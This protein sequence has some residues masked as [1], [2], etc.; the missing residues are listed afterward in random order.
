MGVPKFYRWISERYPCLSEVVR[1]F[2]IPDFDNLYLDMNGIIH[3]CSHPND[4]DPHFRIT[5]DT[6][7]ANI[8]YYIDFLFKMIK[9]K[10]VFFMAIDGVAPRA[11]MNQQRGRRFRTAKAAVILEEQ[12]VALGEDLPKEARFD[13]N[14]ITPGTP[15]MER[16]HTTL[17]GFVVHKMS[18]DKL[19]HGVRVYLS[20]H[21]T[22]GEGE[23]K[24]MDF[25]R[26][27]KSQ[28]GYNPNTRHCLYGLDADLIML[29]ICSHEPHFSLLREEVKFGG[30]KKQKRIATPEETTF[31]LLHISL[32]RDYL[33]HEF[34]PAKSKISFSFDLEK[35][36]DDFVL[37]S[38]LV[39]N[40]FIPHLPQLH[41]HH[42]ALPMLFKTY[43]EVLP[44]LGGYV[45]EE[46]HLNLERFQKFLAKLAE[47]DF[48]K[49]EEMNEDFTY[50]EGKSKA[51]KDA[52]AT[53][54]N[55]TV[56]VLASLGF[57]NLSI[58]KTAEYDSSSGE[59]DTSD[60]ENTLE[61][62]FTMHK[63]DYYMTK[64]ELEASP[65]VLKDQAEG[66][67][68]AI[69]WNLH[70]Y[71]NGVCSWSWYYPH[72]YSP[73][74]SDLKD[75][76]DMEM[77]FELGKPFLPFQQLLAVLPK[78]SKELLPEPYQKLMCE[79]DSPL[80]DS[81]P[82]DFITDLNGKQQEWEAVVLIPFINEKL[83]IKCSEMVNKS[84]TDEEKKRNSH[85]PHL[86]YT[87]CEKPS[88]PIPSFLPGHYP[89][90]SFVHAKLTEIDQDFFR[91]DPDSIYKGL[92][93]GVVMDKFIIGFPTLR[94]L[95]HSAE[96]KHGKV[97][98]FQMTSM[99]DNM[100]LTIEETVDENLD[101]VRDKIL[102]KS[103]Y[104]GWPH[105]R[106]A[107]VV[108]VSD[109]ET[110]F[111]YQ[112]K[113]R[114]SQ[115]FNE[116]K[117]S[118]RD[119]D[120]WFRQMEAAAEHSYV[121][122]GIVTGRI[123]I[124]VHARCFSGSKFVLTKEGKVSEE[125]QY[126]EIATNYALQTIVT[127]VEA[128]SPDVKVDK[129]AEEV[130]KA[131]STVFVLGPQHY[132]V[133]GKIIDCDLI[134]NKGNLMISLEITSEPDLLP[135]I[136]NQDEL[137]LEQYMP[138]YVAA[139]H[140]GVDSHFLSRITGTFLVQTSPKGSSSPNRINIG[141]NLK[142]NRKNEEVQGFSKKVDNQWLYSEESVKTLN[143]Y[144]SKFAEFF[145]K[146]YGFIASDVVY[147]EDI[148]PDGSGQ[149][150]MKDISNWIKEQPCSSADRQ[151]CGIQKLDNGIVGAIERTVKEASEDDVYHIKKAI[152]PSQLY[153]P[154]LC[155][156]VFL[157]DP[158][159]TYQ[160]F[161]RVVNVCPSSSVPLGLKGTVIGIQT[162]EKESDTMYE[163][164]F[165]KEFSGGMALIPNS[166]KGYRM[167]PNSLINL[168]HGERQKRAS[169]T[170]AIRKVVPRLNKA[171]VFEKTLKHLQS[172]DSPPV[173]VLQKKPSQSMSIQGR[174]FYK[175]DNAN[176]FQT[177]PQEA[178]SPQWSNN[179]EFVTP[180]AS[181]MSGG[182][183]NS[184]NGLMQKSDYQNFWADLKKTPESPARLAKHQTS[185]VPKVETDNQKQ[186]A[187]NVSQSKTTSDQG[188]GQK[189]S[190]EELFKGGNK[191]SV[192]DLFK[193]AQSHVE[194][195]H[196]KN[197]QM[198]QH[199]QAPIPQSSNS[200]APRL[201]SPNMI[202][203]QI[204]H[205]VTQRPP[206]ANV[207]NPQPQINNVIPLRT[208]VSNMTAPHPLVPNVAAP[209]PQVPNIPNI[210]S[211]R[212]E[213][214]DLLRQ[215]CLEHLK[216]PPFFTYN[217]YGMTNLFTSTIT[218]PN[219]EKIFS[220]PCNTKL[221]AASNAS[222]KALA[223]LNSSINMSQ[224][225]GNKNVG[226]SMVAHDLNMMTR[227]QAP[228]FQPEFRPLV[229]CPPP[230]MPPPNFPNLPPPQFRPFFNPQH[231]DAPVVR[232]LHPHSTA[233]PDSYVKSNQMLLLD[234]DQSY[235]PKPS[236]PQPQVTN[237]VPPTEKEVFH[238]PRGGTATIRESSLT[239]QKGS[240]LFVPSQVMKQALKNPLD[241]PLS[242]FEW[243]D[244]PTPPKET[245]VE[246]A[247]AENSKSPK[248][249]TKPYA[250]ISKPS[251]QSPSNGKV[252]KTHPAGMTVLKPKAKRRIAANFQ[253]P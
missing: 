42:D 79:N 69:Q 237:A 73:Y 175:I 128:F 15:F 206:V 108:G 236:M 193:G 83:L 211:Q 18:A 26:Y 78:L 89:D 12:A 250:E 198:L 62:E 186:Q 244:L 210:L 91:L 104:I 107:L 112:P 221:E 178:E 226:N 201:S 123:N 64:L 50:L 173:Q 25:I 43:I 117:I 228:N 88:G 4:D 130:F 13:S 209:R 118:S 101:Q 10:K 144:L 103:V 1:E 151:S 119:R 245:K 114:N 75:F 230:F 196:L 207:V 71:Y 158:R 98:V 223:F 113:D 171:A 11:K 166:K 31:H 17:K 72:H 105:L 217:N 135:V 132:G 24:I 208:Q 222:E 49:F 122:W 90:L 35:I 157:P 95:K 41:I 45:N 156:G 180:K 239:I 29:G 16:L 145:D 212:M 86:L 203:S 56:D 53:E 32:L 138:G 253:N 76:K 241:G 77:N 44:S 110:K 84:L 183:N 143:S 169:P 127:K 136:Q 139:Q 39:G 125:K 199:R 146:L 65:E 191:V 163:I 129:A 161:D 179:K 219:G 22:P 216:T 165:D 7:F 213:A 82:D 218:L 181:R 204:S 141:L 37:M 227:P 133:M 38:F 46:G 246:K 5:E 68:R 243:P 40:D 106:E 252:P 121:R 176:L 99:K 251:T 189:L 249:R 97:K 102:G 159:T 167:P 214:P 194:A 87:Y 34:S 229:Y 215:F 164:L 9:P 94:T 153:S 23:H 238:L 116:E 248:D 185:N 126:E 92:C 48:Q 63:A 111:T 195:N 174:P 235:P 240:D 27:E 162:S 184:P 60:E 134:S 6:I 172:N 115:S 190:V 2:Q 188:Y 192:E 55:S 52:E 96:L 231:Y 168:S 234:S 8:C 33:Y 225:G 14:C 149:Q 74:I 47:Y 220:I 187:L 154:Y 160:L 20:G 66:Y 205:I 233:I 93:K 61:L 177:R 155:K 137:I 59:E 80:V 148:Y 200:S 30:K 197:M 58:S 57:S 182:F 152:N 124:L 19:W 224:F 100:M 120:I 81:Y 21:E 109:G 232:H 85:G 51:K 28:P 242:N 36:L 54:K 142:F 131:G 247:F 3:N 67:V 70:Y 140:L 170:K 147:L 150:I 202:P